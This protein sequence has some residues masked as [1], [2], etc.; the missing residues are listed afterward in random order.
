[1][2]WRVSEEITFDSATT[3]QHPRIYTDALIKCVV[4]GMPVPET[5]WRYKGVR[6]I[7][8]LF[9]THSTETTHAHTQCNIKLD[10]IVDL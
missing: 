9:H 6:V 3:P 1:M 8:R 10:R 2:V 5:S 4:S 7:F